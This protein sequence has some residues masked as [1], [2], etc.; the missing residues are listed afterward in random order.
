ML[1]EGQRNLA[2][3]IINVQC[4]EGLILNIFIV[5]NHKYE[6]ALPY[7]ILV[8]HCKSGPEQGVAVAKDNESARK[9]GVTNGWMS[10]RNSDRMGRKSE[11]GAAQKLGEA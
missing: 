11:F 10:G 3:G 8:Q 9:G 7:N 1:A 6:E 2:N 5:N 4:I